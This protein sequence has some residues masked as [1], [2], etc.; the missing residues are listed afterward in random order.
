MV[1]CGLFY[2]VVVMEIGDVW[3]WGME[4]GLG[5][6]LGIGLLGVCN[7]DVFFFVCVF[8]ESFVSCYFVMGV[9]GIICGVVYMVMMV[10]GGKDFWVW[11]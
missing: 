4:G 9:K 3:V 7:G 1:V 10:N 5:L 6:C 11:G 8:G 2:M